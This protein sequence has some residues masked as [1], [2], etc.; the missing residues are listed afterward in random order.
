M[1]KRFPFSKCLSLTKLDSS[2][3]VSI[4][5]V[6]YSAAFS[7][8]SI[9]RYLGLHIFVCYML[10]YNQSLYSTLFS[11][12]L[13]YYTADLPA[14]P[15]GSL[16]GIHFSPILFLIAPL[17]VLFAS[18]ITL[19]TV[20]AVVIGIGALP[21]YYYGVEKLGEKK[22]P[23]FVALAYLISPA[24]VGV[25]WFDFHP[26]V[27]IPPAVMGAVYFWSRKR[28]VKYFA[29]M[30][31][32]LAS[33]ETAPVIVGALGVYLL[34]PERTSLLQARHLRDVTRARVMVPL[35]TI[36]V[37]GIWLVSALLVIKTLNPSNV[38]YFGGSPF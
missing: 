36:V 37:S 16:F 2:A 30:G 21:L 10:N 3:K 22:T 20:Q 23:L 11:W 25:N 14:N 12:K 9:V 13:F 26:E 34:W 28:W 1:T 24:M 15:A 33:I 18:P 27:F 38:F 32:A 8:F 4:I 5:A 19:L 35:I 6:L 29:C 31:T 17:Y 7:F